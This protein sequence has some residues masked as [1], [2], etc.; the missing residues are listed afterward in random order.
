M[1]E[2]L[3]KKLISQTVDSPWTGFKIEALFDDDEHL[4]GTSING[5]KVLGSLAEVE[6]FVDRNQIDEVWIALPLRAE[7]TCKRT[8]LCASPPYR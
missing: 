7:K 8:A 5:Y 2:T 3:V 1:R 4:R 6:T